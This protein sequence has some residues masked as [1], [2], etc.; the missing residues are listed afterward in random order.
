MKRLFVHT[1]SFLR[2]WKAMGLEDDS[3]RQLEDYLLSD[4]QIGDVIPGLN[5]ARK[6]RFSLNDNRGK[7]GG[8]RVIYIDIFQKEKLYLLF[9]YPKCVQEDLSETQKESLNRLILQ[10]K[11]EG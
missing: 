9:A 8:S 6:L 2:C 7:K 11:K 3:L 5:G 4:P 1:E 10:I